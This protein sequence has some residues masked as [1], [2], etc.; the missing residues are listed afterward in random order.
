[1]LDTLVYLK[2]ETPVWFEITT[3]LIPGEN[4]SDAELD[5]MTRWIAE[6]LGPTCRCTS[7]RS[8]PTGR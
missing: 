1:M 7:R 2:R 5:A 6:H 4:D 8:T 3:L